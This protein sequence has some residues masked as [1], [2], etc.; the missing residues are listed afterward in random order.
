MTTGLRI[1]AATEPQAFDGAT[2]VGLYFAGQTD[3]R[4]ALVHVYAADEEV[5]SFV[6]DAAPD[7]NGYA[8]W[9]SWALTPQPGRHSFTARGDGLVT[10][11]IWVGKPPTVLDL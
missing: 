3:G 10:G 9:S 1:I 5:G 8:V 2:K 7:G 6:A 4:E 11:K